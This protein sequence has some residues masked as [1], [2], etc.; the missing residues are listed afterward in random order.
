MQLENYTPL[1]NQNS[2]TPWYKQ[3]EGK[4]C[5]Q[6]TYKSM[7]ITG[8]NVTK[9]FYK[10]GKSDTDDGVSCLRWQRSRERVMWCLRFFLFFSRRLRWDNIPG[11]EIASSPLHG[12]RWGLWAEMGL[13]VG[14]GWLLQKVVTRP[15]PCERRDTRQASPKG[16][17]Y[18]VIKS[19]VAWGGPLGNQFVDAYRGNCIRRIPVTSS[20]HP[21]SLCLPAC[22]RWTPLRN[23]TKSL[24]TMI[25]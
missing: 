7:Y 17:Y 21:L 19:G 15:A 14:G 24:P 6:S 3:T 1:K 8:H 11:I 4:K 18:Y 10:Q 9:R 22:I 12:W 16:F 25:I 23:L 13:W 20:R 5:A 2:F